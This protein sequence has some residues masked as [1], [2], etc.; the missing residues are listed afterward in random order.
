I[1]EQRV[2]DNQKAHIL[3]LKRR[4]YEDIVLT[5]HTPYPSRKIRRIY[6]LNFTQHP[7][8]ED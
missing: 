7:R 1:I 2:K 3:E 6:A 8:R 4:N 5:T